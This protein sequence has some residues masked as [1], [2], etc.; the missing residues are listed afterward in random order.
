MHTEALEEMFEFEIRYKTDAG[1]P[2]EEEAVRAF[3]Y[4]DRSRISHVS[5][6]SWGE[7]CTE[8]AVPACFHTCDLYERRSDGLCRRFVNG[9]VPVSVRGGH[10]GGIVRIDFKPWGKLM[11]YGNSHLVPVDRAS[12]IESALFRIDSLASALPATSWPKRRGRT[13]IF[14]PASYI[15]KKAI[16]NSGLFSS[17]RTPDAFCLEAFNPAPQNVH[18]VL[19]M[20][21][22]GET[23]IPFIYKLVL[24][25]GISEI[26]IPFAEING[27]PADH[28]KITMQVVPEIESGRSNP[29]T[30]YFGFIGFAKF[31]AATRRTTDSPVKVRH[32]KAIIWDL[33]NT[34]W[35]GIL[36]ESNPSDIRLRNGVRDLIAEMDRRGIVNSV[37]SKNEYDST[38]KQLQNLGIADYFVFPKINWSPKSENIRAIVQDLNIGLDTVAFIDDQPFEREQVRSVY[39]DVRVYTE[40]QIAGLLLLPEFNPQLSGESANRR[41]FYQSQSVRQGFQE[42]FHDDYFSFLS[43]CDICLTVS[44]GTLSHLD[45][46]H[47]LSQRTNQLNFS[48]NRYNHEKIVELLNDEEKDLFVLDCVD[49]FGAYGTIGLAIVDKFVR[50]SP[51]VVDL[52]FSCR[53]QAKRIEHSLLNF[54]ISKYAGEG[55]RELIA[56][57][58]KTSRNAPAGKV[59]GDLGFEEMGTIDGLTRLRVSDLSQPKMDGIVTVAFEGATRKY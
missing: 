31:T 34:L 15:F 16:T 58:K 46:I 3:E 8:C 11:A 18:L 19:D 47:E 24:A 52:M 35:N 7:H 50:E 25:P 23:R 40:N 17:A 26:A 20:K 33:D 49:R 42:Q 51:A 54:L 12:R 10:F 45:R 14:S 32:V 29:L 55:A 6:I 30:L 21:V 37:A 22:P 38:W 27:I 43:N 9:I 28:G 57:W 36:T 56:L 59:F 53:V 48:G 2:A 5:L 4:I 44:R 39:P 13:G 1:D 41:I